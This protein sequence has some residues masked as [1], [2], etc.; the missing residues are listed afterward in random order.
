LG[1]FS[2]N[3]IL[4]IL[5]VDRPFQSDDAVSHDD[6]DIVRI[7]REGGIAGDGPADLLREVAVGS[8]L[9]LLIRCGGILAAGFFVLLGIVWLR[10][11]I[12]LCEG[13]KT[14]GRK[15]NDR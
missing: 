11:G 3:G 15:P 13:R 4:L 1:G 10:L 2:A 14:G 6:L 7:D 9:F 8:G 5:G 12:C